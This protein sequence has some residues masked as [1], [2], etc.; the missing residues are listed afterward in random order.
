M[1]CVLKKNRR[2]YFLCEIGTDRFYGYVRG[3]GSTADKQRESEQKQLAVIR[4][5][6]E[7]DGYFEAYSGNAELKKQV[8]P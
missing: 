6:I 3:T 1:K 7:R 4:A 8:E 2:G 5:A